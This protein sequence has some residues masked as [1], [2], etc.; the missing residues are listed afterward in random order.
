VLV[1]LKVAEP[2]SRR[3]RARPSTVIVAEVHARLS[4]AFFCVAVAVAMLV[5]GASAASSGGRWRPLLE[6]PK[7]VDA[8]G[9]RADGRLVLSTLRG[10]FLLRPGGR[11]E[12]FANGTG[13][14]AASRGEPYIALAPER[15]LPAAKCSF[16]RDDVFALDADS[17][18]GVTRVT[19]TGH[20]S[21]LLDLP[22]GAFPSGIAF[23]L[24]GRFGFRLLVTVIVDKKTTLYAIDCLGHAT[25]LVRGA[26]RVEGGMVVAPRSFGRFAGEL[27]AP[28]ETT[29]RIYA[30]APAGNVRLVV[31]SGL[32]AGGDIGVEGLGFVP[33]GLG[34][35]GAAYFSDLGA[36]GAP[37]EGTNSLLVLR[38]RDLERA[39]LR[40]GE[41]VASTEAGA[42]TIAVRCARRCSVRHVA[43]GPRAT[44]GEGHVTFVPG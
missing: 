32:R 23:D 20:A 40:A 29:G 26:P 43:D 6:V 7:I 4:A 9:P 27:I 21:R 15:R 37:T 30:F 3:R 25:V 14:Y 28:N 11:A 36:P 34:S 38:G 8:V 44:H 1:A 41:L 13:G 2:S 22:A 35:R 39:G 33:A 42:I 17:G 18:P 31:K 10:L 16:E 5:N 19:S 24:A 12:A